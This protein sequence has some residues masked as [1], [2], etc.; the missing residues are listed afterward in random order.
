MSKWIQTENNGF[1]NVDHI[2]LIYISDNRVWAVSECGSYEIACYNNNKD[3]HDC[4]NN[5]MEQLKDSKSIT[6]KAIIEE[7]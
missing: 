3:A 2:Q 6:I 7:D 4:L 1:L 5:I